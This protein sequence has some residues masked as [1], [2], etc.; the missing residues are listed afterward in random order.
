LARLLPTGTR[1]VY[2]APDAALT[3]LPW[4]ALPGVKAGT[5]L[6]EEYTLAVVPYGQ[7][8]LEALSSS[9]GRQLTEEGRLLALGAVEYDPA[10][11][12]T[13]ATWPALPGT[14][15]E[16]ERVLTLAGNRPTAT[17]RGKD[18]STARLLK[19]LPKARWAHLATHGF[20]ADRALR[21]V[22]QF[23]TDDF[24][25]GQKGER[26]GVGARNPLVLS[27][28]VLAGANEHKE[29]GG[30]LT[31]E[32]IAGLDLDGLE[33]AVL[34]ACDTGLGEVAGGEGVFG[35]QRAFH[36][37]GAQNVIASLW[38]V[39]DEATAALMALFYHHLWVE[40]QAPL[41]ALRQAQLTLY[42]H[43]D[44]IPVLARE[45]GLEFNKAA[46]VPTDARAPRRAPARLWAGF[47]LSGAGR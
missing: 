29:D 44:R 8:L 13:K 20:F 23:G 40:K 46:R 12:N 45:R 7:F 39:D 11:A 4:A 3:G 32:A 6:L 17:L 10:P 41:E 5:V 43:P 18:A 24:R 22:F 30:V 14:A 34:S 21:S 37:A 26:V 25:R 16:L 38:K 9:R 2:L 36:L 1:T 35:L 47:V 19:D 28:L 42:R 15:G 27:G 33:L 31:A